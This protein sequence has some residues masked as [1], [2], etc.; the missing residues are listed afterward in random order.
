LIQRSRLLH[1]VVFKLRSSAF[2]DIGCL[3]KD[4]APLGGLR[5]AP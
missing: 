1:H 4:L 2:N 3:Q 5:L